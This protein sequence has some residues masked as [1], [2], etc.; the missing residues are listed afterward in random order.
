MRPDSDIDSGAQAAPAAVD[1]TI[2]A[3][4]LGA[5]GGMERQLAELVL[6]L[7]GMGHDVTVIARTCELPPDSGVHFHRVRGPGRPF[8]LAYP[9]F[10]VAGSL[11]VRRWRRGVVQATG[12]IVLNRIDVVAI[13][14]CHQVGPANPSRATPLFRW[15][16][17]LA[18]VLKRVGER[19]CLRVNRP[20]VVVC[21]SEGVSEEIRHHF[22]RLA[23]RVLTIHNGVDTAAFAPALRV[24]D[25]RARRTALGL[26]H[27]LVAL[28]VGSEWTRKGLEPAIRAL[29][30]APD[31][32][33]VVAGGGDDESYM[34]LAEALGVGERLRLL[35][36]TSDVQPLYQMSDAFLLASSY[37][38]FSLVTFEAAAS[39]LPILATAVSGVRELLQDAHNGFL[40][41]RE[42]ELIAE[43]LNRLAADPA[44]RLR[45]GGAARESALAFD[46]ARMV[47]EHHALYA[48]LSGASQLLAC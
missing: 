42:P 16:V 31:W 48:R 41:T 9:W 25:A 6:G 10:M 19:L 27:A 21:V 36:V 14:Y 29:A 44:L 20:A 23:D 11:A 30:G 15:H 7:R 22:P 38:T 47:D 35:G 12:A 13:H 17:R 5:V 28:F 39:G 40:I 46:W 34:A 4:D 18:S 8:A 3:H 45:L 26:E 32:S 1:V 33:L 37:E 24:E 2:V 43:R